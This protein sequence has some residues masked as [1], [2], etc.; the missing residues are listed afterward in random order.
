MSLFRRAVRILIWLIVAVGG[1][2]V[3]AAAFLARRVVAP[4]RQPLWAAPDD[5]GMGYESIQFPAR[6]D[7]ARLS[8]WFLP[9]VNGNGRTV[10]VVHGWTWNRLGDAAEGIAADLIGASAVDL[11]RF[12]H[13]LHHAGYHVAMLDLRNHGESADNPPVTFGYRESNDLLGMLDYLRKRPEV[14]A[15]RIGVVG[16]STGANTLLYTL[17]RTEEIKAA[18][19][20]Q[21]T[22]LDHFMVRMGHHLFGPFG[23]VI[24][25][26]AEWMVQ[27][28]GGVSFSAVDPLF[29][30]PSAGQT[31]VL[32]VQGSGDRW[33]SVENVQD[34][35]QKTAG[36][37]DTLIV[38]TADRYGG[39]QYVVN[40]PEI[41]TTFFE[42]YL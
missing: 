26:L 8:G 2:V 3:G 1:F 38:E 14:D 37:I 30:V 31:P 6:Q 7:A 25:S 35:A 9:A 34:I 39:Y 36:A 4:P 13:A 41:V 27:Q 20:V 19:A 5:V 33:G 11:L 16:Y 18:V 21:P 23:R 12:A 42:D 40:H 10:I 32:F 22:S 17:T 29:A 28:M 24:M 15:E